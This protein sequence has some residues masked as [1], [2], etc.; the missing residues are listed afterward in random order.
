MSLSETKENVAVLIPCCNEEA[1]VAQ[2]VKAVRKVLPA[3]TIYVY[4]NESED[5]TAEVAAAAGAVVRHEQNRGKGNVMRRMFADVE[6][7]YYVTIDGDGAFELEAA[8]LML[9]RCKQENLDMVVGVRQPVAGQNPHRPGHIF[10]N[11]MLNKLLELFFF[12]R[13]NDILSGYR[14]LTRRFV[15]SFP[16]LSGGFQI[17]T[18]MSVHALILGLRVAEHPVNYF[19]RV[20][21]VSKLRTYQDGINILIFMIRLFKDYRPLILFSILSLI[22]LIV[23]TLFFVPIFI[24]FLDTSTVSRIPTLIACGVG[25]LISLLLLFTGFIL[26][27][28]ARV[29]L[30][31]K[32]LAYLQTK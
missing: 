22:V 25:A 18:E 3:A 7:D 24:E 11:W 4:D 29:A 17:E 26:D 13:F 6:A 21:G 9:E 19:P 5:N 32:Q 27:S 31:V 12:R 23:T 30:K 15:K 14:V 28:I 20:G 1:S 8:S 2:V 16:V 10:G